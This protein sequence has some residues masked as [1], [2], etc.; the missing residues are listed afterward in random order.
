VKK[1]GT[2]FLDL[3]CCLGQ[4]LRKLVYDGAPAENV[5]G[6]DLEYDFL[7]LGYDLFRDQDR[8]GDKFLEADIFQE[9]C[10]GN[11]KGR[12]DII[13]IGLFLHLWNWEWQLKACLAIVDILKQKKGATVLGQQMAS[14]EPGAVKYGKKELYKHDVRT[15]ERLWKEVGEKT[16]TKWEVTASMDKGLGVDKGERKWDTP[17]I[18]RRLVFK[19]VRM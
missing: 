16:G 8:L 19:V 13:H 9:E 11:L 4:D 14:I 17:E 15:F 7:K 10:L 5:W 1:E 12:V 3:G 18:S 2:I 6:A